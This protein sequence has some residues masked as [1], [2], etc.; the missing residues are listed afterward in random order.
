MADDPDW[1]KPHRPLSPPRQPQPG[2]RLF[3]FYVERDHARWLCELRDHGDV[4]RF[5][6]QFFRKKNSTA[7]G[8][9]T[10]R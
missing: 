9:S 3:E 7:V 2:E 6:A 10:A 8:G 5:E 4:Y 1:Y